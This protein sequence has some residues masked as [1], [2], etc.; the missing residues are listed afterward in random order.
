MIPVYNNGGTIREVALACRERLP[1]VVVIDDGSTDAD[2]RALLT[3]TDIHVIRHEVNQG[4]GKA[5]M[6]ALDYVAE[7]NAD[8]LIAI[9]GD[10]QHKAADLDQ[11]IPLLQNDNDTLWIGVRDFS[12]PNVIAVS[13]SGL[14]GKVW[15]KRFPR[16]NFLP[17]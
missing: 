3:D 1:H 15:T 7:K 4:K 13:A 16:A 9:D 8:Y 6:T 17:E 10:G 12:K 5:L 14:V 2:I 11:F